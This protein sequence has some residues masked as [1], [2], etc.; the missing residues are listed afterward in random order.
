MLWVDPTVHIGVEGV[1]V[2]EGVRV[3]QGECDQPGKQLD[4]DVNSG[5]HTHTDHVCNIKCLAITFP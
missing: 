3:P 5:F 4:T 1:D 2:V